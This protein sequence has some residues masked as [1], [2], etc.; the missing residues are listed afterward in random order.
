MKFIT[1]IC[2]TL[3]VCA[4]SAQ[5]EPPQTH[6]SIMLDAKFFR[7]DR[8]NDGS[9]DNANRFQVRKAEICFEGELADRAEYSTAIG[10]CTCSGNA[11]TVDIPEAEI[12]YKLHRNI[13]LGLRKGHVLRGFNS[14]IECDGLLASEKPHYSLAFGSCHP[15]GIVASSHHELPHNMVIETEISA[16][17]GGN[18]TLDNEHEYNCGVVFQTPVPGLS[19]IAVYDH[20]N[21]KYYDSLFNQ[22]SKNG[23]RWAAGLEYM[24]HSLWISS[25]YQRGK[26][27][28][29]DEQKMEAWYIQ[30]GWEIGTNLKALPAIQPYAYY[31][32]W[33]R[34]IGDDA[35]NQYLEL[36]INFKTLPNSM[37]RVAYK[38]M[39]DKAPGSLADPDQLL[40]RIQISI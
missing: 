28:E 9:Y 4:L 36:G 26:G 18:S 39:I 6:I 22:Y 15:I 16:L 33:N 35:V 1:A 3:F 29:R 17:N 37:L 20:V 7:G 13:K 10:M 31:E 2:F 23:Y 30:A 38:S 24:A 5:I 11:A 14:R 25:E 19:A 27:F 21:R 40:A 34:D 32:N 8:A 12:M